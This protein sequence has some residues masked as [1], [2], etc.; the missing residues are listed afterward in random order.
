MSNKT[1]MNYNYILYWITRKD[2]DLKKFSKVIQF[3][4]FGHSEEVL[5][6]LFG[7]RIDVF[8]NKYNIILELF[9]WAQISYGK[10]KNGLFYYI[11]AV[12]SL[13][14]SL[15]LRLLI[16]SSLTFVFYYYRGRENWPN[17]RSKTANSV[18][19][20]LMNSLFH[21]KYLNWFLF[22]LKTYSLYIKQNW[23]FKSKIRL[24]YY[25]TFLLTWVLGEIMKTGFGKVLQ[26]SPQWDAVSQRRLFFVYHCLMVDF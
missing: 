23:I 7:L 14:S 16:G 20:Y 3:N 15:K 21:Y 11:V 1:L 5:H 4:Y 24:H 8:I 25:C 12:Y 2:I 13:K 9:S 26:I 22:K 18:A 19:F 10:V 6:N 17:L